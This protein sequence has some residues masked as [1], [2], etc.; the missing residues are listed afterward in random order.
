MTDDIDPRDLIAESYRI[1]GIRPGECR[2]IFLDW[3]LG[4]PDG[5]QMRAHIV[6]LIERHEPDAPDHAMT[7]VLKQA[8]AEPGAK[9]RRGGAAA[10]RRG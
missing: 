4:A 9:G 10:R 1:E 6:R 3:A 7:E 2:S 8:L 5:D